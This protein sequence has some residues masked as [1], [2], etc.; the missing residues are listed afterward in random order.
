MLLICYAH[1]LCLMVRGLD[2]AGIWVISTVFDK[3][4]SFKQN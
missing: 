1:N 2:K 3:T 4:A